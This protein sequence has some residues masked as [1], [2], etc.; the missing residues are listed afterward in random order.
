MLPGQ[1]KAEG[2]DIWPTYQKVQNAKEECRPKEIAVN[3]QCAQVL[4]QQL[5]DHTTSRV[6]AHTAVE[7]ECYRLQR[8]MAA[9]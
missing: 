9:I 1:S 3:E 5:L 8:K 4:L 6:F 2:S 7:A